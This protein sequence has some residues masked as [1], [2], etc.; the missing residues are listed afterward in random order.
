M[1]IGVLNLDLLPPKNYIGYPNCTIKNIF[2]KKNF[3]E[4]MNFFNSFVKR[5]NLIS[6]IDLGFS[7][8]KNLVIQK[9]AILSRKERKEDQMV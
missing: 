5:F 8:I 2:D 7:A 1:L 4:T 6:N 9:K 3:R